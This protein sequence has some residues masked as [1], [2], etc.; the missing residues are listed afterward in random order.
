VSCAV[1]VSAFHYFRTPVR[2]LAAIHDVLRPGGRLLI[3]DRAREQSLLTVLWQYAHRFLIRDNVQFS[4]STEIAGMLEQ[5]GFQDVRVLS[6]LRKVLWKNKLYTSLV[7][8]QGTRPQP[9]AGDPM[10]P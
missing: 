4:S 10:R 8:I 1:C 5:A 2:A 7:L 3:L 9:P 6:R